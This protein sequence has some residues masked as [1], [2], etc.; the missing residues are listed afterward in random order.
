M[1]KDNTDAPADEAQEVVE[2]QG[3]AADKAPEAPEKGAE[4][5]SYRVLP[6]GDDLVFTGE[7]DKVK[8][9]PA[10]HARGTIVHN[11]DRAIAQELEDR[12]LVEIVG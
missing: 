4:T 3:A 12:G 10:K 11:V 2:A 8:N 7:H 1:A 5:V 9:E 6:K